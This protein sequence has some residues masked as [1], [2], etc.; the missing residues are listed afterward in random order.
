MRVFLPDVMIF[1]SI[2]VNSIAGDDSVLVPLTIIHGLLTDRR[3]HDR[4]VSFI[5]ERVNVI[6]NDIQRTSIHVCGKYCLLF[7]LLFPSPLS[8][9][10]F[11]TLT[12]PLLHPIS[13][14]PILTL[15][16]SP[17]PCNFSLF[18]IPTTLLP[19]LVLTPP[20]Y[21]TLLRHFQV[22]LSVKMES[23]ITVA[24]YVLVTSPD[25]PVP[26]TRVMS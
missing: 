22:Q 14:F 25:T 26:V 17:F 8:L 7:I 9:L 23:L 21:H 19:F 15:P 20:L 12:P 16:S 11:S 5:C 3:N 2:E 13:P 6:G 4:R 1:P 18:F 24:I 10:P